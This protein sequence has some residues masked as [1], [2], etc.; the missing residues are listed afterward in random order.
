MAYVIPQQIIVII[1][2]KH[3]TFFCDCLLSASHPSSVLLSGNLLKSV[4]Q[5][6]L[7]IKNL[8][9]S[10][11][12][13]LHRLSFVK[14][15][16]WRFGYFSIVLIIFIHWHHFE[17]NGFYSMQKKIWSCAWRNSTFLYD[18]EYWNIIRS[19]KFSS[20]SK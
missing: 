6:Y 4:L 17:K 18:C 8:N 16:K 9:A 12:W 1:S 2:F 15:L 3:H 7:L 10:F 13:N 5:F 19:M 20:F 11:L 14:Q